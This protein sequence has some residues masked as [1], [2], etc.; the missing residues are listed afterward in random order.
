M[1]NGLYYWMS[2]YD[3]YYEAMKNR[4]LEVFTIDVSTIQGLETL[5]AW[6]NDQLNGSTVAD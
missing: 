3:K 6:M 4:T 2:G 5:K 1:S